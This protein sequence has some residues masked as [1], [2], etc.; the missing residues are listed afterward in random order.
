MSESDIILFG[1][2]IVMAVNFFMLRLP[3]WEDRRWLFYGCQSLNIAACA[4]MFLK[5]IPDFHGQL[6]IVNI[7]VGLLFIYHAISNNNRLQTILRR[8]KIEAQRT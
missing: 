2:I 3:Q 4:F 7:M 8:K 1:M 5:G 6:D